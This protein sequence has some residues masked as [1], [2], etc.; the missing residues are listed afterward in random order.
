MVSKNVATFILYRFFIYSRI[1]GVRVL[2][3]GKAHVQLKVMKSGE[4]KTLKD[5]QYLLD[6]KIVIWGKGVFVFL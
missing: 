5:D 2:L 6:E 4:R 3:R 1:R